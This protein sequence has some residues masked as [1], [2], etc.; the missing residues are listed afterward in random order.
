MA[1]MNLG[2]G[3]VDQRVVGMILDA[4]DLNKDGKV[5]YN[6]FLMQLRY[7]QLPFRSYNSKLRHKVQGN[8]EE[9]IGPSNLK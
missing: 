1:G 6:E 3:L 9:P 2:P 8:P 4:M 7:G 5:Q